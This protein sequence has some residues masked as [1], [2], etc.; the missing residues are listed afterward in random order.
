M[1]VS[2]KEESHCSIEDLEKNYKGIILF[3][4]TFDGLMGKLFFKNLTDEITS[5]LKRINKTF[6]NNFYI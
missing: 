5:L 6:D 2:D 1:Q 3:S 4:G